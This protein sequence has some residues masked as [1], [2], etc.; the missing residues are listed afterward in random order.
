MG[1]KEAALD[2]PTFRAG[3]FHFA[4]QV[5]L[6][7]RWLDSWLKS[8]MKIIQEA[9]ALAV[10]VNG[11]MSDMIPPTFSEAVLDH[12]YTLLTLN[13]YGEGS[14]ELWGSMILGMKKMDDNMV[15]PVRNLIQND[16]KAFKVLSIGTIERKQRIT[17]V[18]IG[19]SP[20]ARTDSE[21]L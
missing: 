11:F 12:D 15:E 5:D 17:H 10:A 21:S 4:D 18:S 7:E 2:S 14:R 19:E 9:G 3:V 13:T 6:I 20:R 8:A 16:L 1:L